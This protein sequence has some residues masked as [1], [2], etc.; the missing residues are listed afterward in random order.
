MEMSIKGAE[1]V[2]QLP[3]TDGGR[4]AVVGNRKKYEIFNSQE[5]FT[6]ILFTEKIYKYEYGKKGNR[7]NF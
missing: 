7:E 2:W 6:K 4:V 1:G 3:D 5:I